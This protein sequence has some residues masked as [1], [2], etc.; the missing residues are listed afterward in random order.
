[1]Q[2]WIDSA[3]GANGFFCSKAAAVDNSFCSGSGGPFFGG[4]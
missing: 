1:M 3:L 2:K 4:P